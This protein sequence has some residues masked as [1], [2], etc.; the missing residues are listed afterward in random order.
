MSNS[1][2]PDAG[3]ERGDD[4][5][6]LFVVQRLVEARLLHVEDLALEREHGLEVAVA[7]LL[8]A[9]AGRVALDEVDLG[10]RRVAV[11]A[12]GELAGQRAALERVLPAREFLRLARRL[13]AARGADA[14]LDDLLR[15]RRILLEVLR[16]RG[17]H[18]AVDDAL[19]FAVAELGLGLALELRLLDLHADHCGEAFAD[20]ITAELD[21]VLLCEPAGLGIARDAARQRGLEAREMGPALDRVDVVAVGVDLL[22]IA[23]VVLHRDLDTRRCPARR[24]RRWAAGGSLPCSR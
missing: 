14:L 8:G 11:A 4:R 16:E 1:S 20:V 13:A 5:L 12:V 21:L 17:D 3:T 6:D 9:A 19:D 24:A 18:E 15:D 22:A 10:H 7:R 2:A 23:L